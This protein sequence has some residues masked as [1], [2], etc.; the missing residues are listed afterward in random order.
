LAISPFDAK[1]QDAPGTASPQVPDKSR[2]SL[3]NPTPSRFMRQLST[4]RPDKTES[5]YTLDAGHFQLEMDLVSYT[6]DHDTSGGG[7]TRTDLLA[8]APV[9]LKIGLLNNLDFQVV[10]ESYN[11]G[12]VSDHAAGTVQTMSG[13]GDVTTRLKLNFWGNDGGTTAFAAI[14][15]VKFPSNQDNLGNSA[16]EGAV[17]F[18]LALQL[19]RGWDMAPM[20]GVAFL[21]DENNEGYHASFINSIT[22]GRELFGKLDGY[23]EFFSEVSTEQGSGWIGTADFGVTY[24]LTPNIQLDAGINIGVTKAAPDFNPFVGLSWRF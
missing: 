15:L 18:P 23:A 17:L 6:R 13:F 22:F 1:A 20:A 11:H 3:F 19:P 24:E 2:Y 7:D 14:P 4:D 12:R 10:L 8:V 5:A 21:R 16:V 9:N